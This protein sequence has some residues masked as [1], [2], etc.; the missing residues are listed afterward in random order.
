M[1]AEVEIWSIFNRRLIER[2]V[3]RTPFGGFRKEAWA[4]RE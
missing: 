4:A 3:M 2:G 1:S